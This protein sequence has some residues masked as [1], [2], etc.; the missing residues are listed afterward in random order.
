MKVLRDNIDWAKRE[1]RIFLKHSLETRLIGMYDQ[2]PLFPYEWLKD[3]F[4]FVVNWN[5]H[6]S[7]K[8][9]H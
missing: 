9:S 7:S 2:L 8:R 4:Y 6:S 5:L 1:K 3:R